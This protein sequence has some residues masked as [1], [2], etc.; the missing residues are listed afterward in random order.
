MTIN[1]LTI[2]S[3]TKLYGLGVGSAKSVFQF[4]Y[5]FSVLGG[6]QGTINLTQINGALPNKFVVQNVIVDV[7][8]ALGSGGAALAALTTGQSAGDLQAATVVAGAP[9]S[10]AGMKATTILL[11]TIATQVKM[12][13]TR[14]PA[15]VVTVADLNAG[16]INVFV[17]GFQSS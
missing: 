10:S 3:S 17:E 1:A 2:D 4:V 12:T 6:A 15:L 9:W 7:V 5:D 16:L 14:T 11:G 13:A 8:T